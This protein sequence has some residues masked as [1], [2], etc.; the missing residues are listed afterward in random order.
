MTV[1]LEAHA[2][3]LEGRCGVEQAEALFGHIETHPTLP[4][5]VSG[6]EAVHTALWQVILMFKPRL[7][8]APNN[9]F[10]SEHILPA[11]AKHYL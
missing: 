3:I 6:A 5:D 8:G 10:I 2:I 11:L 7:E 9:I 1:R 4:V